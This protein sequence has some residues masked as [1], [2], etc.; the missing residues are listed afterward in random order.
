MSPAGHWP[1]LRAAIEAGA[2]AVYFGLHHFTARAR[3]GFD[4]DELPQAVEALHG[5]GVKAFVTFNTLVFDHELAQAAETIAAIAA[6]GADA[7]I[8]QDVGIARLARAVCPELEIHGSTQM[9]VTSAEGAELARHFGCS[10]VVLARELSLEDIGRVKAGT[11][12]ELEVFVHGA[13]CVSYSG[14]CFSS[15]AWGGRS[16]NRGQC[17]QAC[18]LPYDL[19]VDGMRR[20]LG[21]ARYLLSPG[22]LMA[23]EQVPELV[24]RGVACF[25]IEGRYKDAAY[26]AATTAAYRAAIDAAMEEAAF[27]PEPGQLADL[28]QVYSRGLGPWFIAGANH[29]RAVNGRAPRH[30]GRFAGRVIE[31]RRG[32]VLIEGALGLARG[33]GVVFDA[34]DRRSPQLKEQ[35]GFLY[36]VT[37]AGPGRFEL[38]FSQAGIDLADISPGDLVW[39]THDPGLARR[40]KPLT[41]ANDPVRLIPVE[42]RLRAVVGEPLGLEFAISGRPGEEA[43]ERIAVHVTSSIVEAARSAPTTDEMLREQSGRLG[44]SPFRLESLAIERSANAFVPVS[45]LNQL[46]RDAVGL[47]SGRLTSRPIRTINRS[48]LESAVWRTGPARDMA[49]RETEPHCHVLVRQPGQ[50][51]G[52]IAAQPDSITLDY[53]ELYGLR[54]SVDRVRAAGIAV[55][56]A[57]PRVLKPAEERIRQ[58]LVSLECDLLVRSG[59][60]LW[61]LTQL[62]ADR[63]P[64]LHGDFSLNVANGLAARELSSLGLSRLTPG[65][66]LNADQVCELA[67][68]ECGVPLELV[69]FQHLPVFHTEHCVFCRFMTSG[70]DHTNCGHPC[71]SHQVALRDEEG[72]LHPLLADVGCRNT[73]FNAEVQSAAGH[74]TAFLAAGIRDFRLEFVH[75]SAVQVQ[76]ATDA[77]RAALNGDIDSAA[78]ERAF[79]QSAGSRT[80]EGSLYVPKGYRKLVQLNA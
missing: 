76:A 55:R 60:L 75:Q 4:L 78:L 2:D 11:S 27:V 46:R 17:A 80:T 63:R 5:R 66:D 65:H 70:T 69:I 29:Q 8:V 39:K 58:F 35:G 22:D 74:L 41:D 73:V 62:P 56:V 19:M 14:Q 18:R 23:L 26:V 44:G 15:E 3:T 51:D 47:L 40:L 25:K 57:S 52:A 61:S 9:S 45:A 68:Q 71:E 20:E 54:A 49:L 16:A 32:N 53:L 13:L 77:A 36:D 34:A 21:A 33:D 48:L 28:E 12:L 31:V 50:L 6:S 30:R 67:R 38:R 1:Q 37:P 59:G 64:A 10:R 7:M 42:G 43:A 79:L 24:R 72:R